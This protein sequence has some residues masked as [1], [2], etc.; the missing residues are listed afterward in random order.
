[1]FGLP[2]LLNENVVVDITNA[3]LLDTHQYKIKSTIYEEKV[4]R[5][6][7]GIIYVNTIVL[8]ENTDIQ[9]LI[10]KAIAEERYE[11]A[12]TLRDKIKS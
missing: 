3:K 10:K 4:Y 7:D 2:Y 12:A 6:A 9:L 8:D 11:D 5:L 1:M